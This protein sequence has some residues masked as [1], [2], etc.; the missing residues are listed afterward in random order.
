MEGTSLVPRCS[1][2]AA[3]LQAGS[4][5]EREQTEHLERCRRSRSPRAPL[6]LTTIPASCQLFSASI[7]TRSSRWGCKTA[8]GAQPCGRA[9]SARRKRWRLQAASAGPWWLLDPASLL[10]RRRARREGEES[11]RKGFLPGCIFAVVAGWHLR[12][13]RRGCQ[14]YCYPSFMIY[15]LR[16]RR[17]KTQQ[18]CRVI[19]GSNH[20]AAPIIK[21]T[22]T[23]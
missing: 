10:L 13:A 21:T 2:G 22:C 23:H 18:F 6:L 16:K 11:C 1:G 19:L 9:R 12:R 3:G 15:N 20:P 7:R 5:E 17:L 4:R 14:V 8:V